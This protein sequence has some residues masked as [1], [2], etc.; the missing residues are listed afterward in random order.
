MAEGTA[1]QSEVTAAAAAEVAPASA[2]EPPA[3][4]E[5]AWSDVPALAAAAWI[6][7]WISASAA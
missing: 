5:R 7:A 2:L 3:D 4:A 1:R 6:S